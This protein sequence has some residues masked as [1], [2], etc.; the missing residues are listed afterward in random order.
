[1][2]VNIVFTNQV[3]TKAMASDGSAK[4]IT[5]QIGRQV[6][7]IYTVDP[8]IPSLI[9][10]A[11]NKCKSLI[12]KSSELSTARFKVIAF[13][14]SKGEPADR[15]ASYSSIQNHLFGEILPGGSMTLDG[16]LCTSDIYIFSSTDLALINVTITE[17]Q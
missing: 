10:Q 5:Y 4:T 3:P 16:D 1:M 15:G 9:F 14:R 11:A 2:A 17:L 6:K 13:D 12:F 8:L 7:C